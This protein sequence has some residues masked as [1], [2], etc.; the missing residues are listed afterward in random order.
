MRLLIFM[1]ELNEHEQAVL[2]IREAINQLPVE[3]RARVL[4]T[5]GILRQA[6]ASGGPCAMM[7]LG[8]V[9]AELAAG[10]G[11]FTEALGAC[12]ECGRTENHTHPENL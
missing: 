5:A 9:G 7:A 8:L 12:P 1:S 10:D 6:M 3:E 11:S 2:D 4:M